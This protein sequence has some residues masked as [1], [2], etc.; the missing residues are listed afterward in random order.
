MGVGQETAHNR[1]GVEVGV[2]QETAHNRV[3]VE[4]GVGQETA[5]EQVNN[6]EPVTERG[7]GRTN[8]EGNRETITVSSVFLYF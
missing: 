1:V 5:Q 7:E 8:K 4:V 2:G 3:G 6:R